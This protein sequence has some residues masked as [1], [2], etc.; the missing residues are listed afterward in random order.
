MNDTTKISENEL[1]EVKS[2]QDKFQRQNYLIGQMKINR[3]KL[4]KTLKE[5]IEQEEK[6]LVDWDVLEKEESDLV[7]RL[8]SKYGEGSLDLAAGTFT[9]DKK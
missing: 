4:E 5:L 7:N 6:L 3:R 9:P 1:K 8:L 2:L